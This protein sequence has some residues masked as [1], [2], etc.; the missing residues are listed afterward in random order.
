MI[1]PTIIKLPEST[2]ILGDCI[3]VMRQWPDNKFKLAIVD[4][5]YFS[6]PEKRKYYGQ[7]V[8]G[9]NVKRIDYPVTG[10]W[11][12]PREDYFQELLRVSEHQIIWGCNYFKWHF[13][14]G[15]IIWDKVNFDSSFSDCE[16]A[17]CSLHD[18]I[19]LV[20]YMWNG[21]MQGKSLKEGH[22]M[23][24]NKKLNE[25]RIHP[26]Q[27]P[28]LLYKWILQQY[29]QEGWNI[30]DTHLGSGS[31]RIAAYDM[32][33]D[34]TGIEIT[35]THFDRQENRF[36]QHAQKLKLGQW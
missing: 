20:R 7:R 3:E 9:K 23:Q 29:A 16:E 25:K 26:T 13:G 34:F 14:P 2:V 31:H 30:L 4:P 8:S 11:N 12:V 28:I 18:S 27:K 19:R 35:D 17:Y 6:G 33:F 36:Q 5:P 24:G 32:G 21:M 22:V 1:T 10:E 15:R